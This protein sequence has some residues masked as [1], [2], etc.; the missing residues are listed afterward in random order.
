[1]K[2]LEKKTKQQKP[3]LYN[4]SQE[5]L[6]KLSKN[7]KSSRIKF[8]A[9]IGGVLVF[10]RPDFVA[11]LEEGVKQCVIDNLGLFC[12]KMIEQPM[13]NSLALLALLGS[14]VTISSYKIRINAL[15]KA[16]QEIKD[17]DLSV[18]SKKQKTLLNVKCKLTYLA[19]VT[20]GLIGLLAV[21]TDVNLNLA[22]Y[23]IIQ[24]IADNLLHA[25]EGAINEPLIAAAFAGTTFLIHRK[26][27]KLNTQKV[28]NTMKERAV[29][30]MNDMAQEDNIIETDN[31]EGE[32]VYV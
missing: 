15:K 27:N 13:V 24:P 8:A 17:G 20:T 11:G 2:L 4:I 26:L 19:E 9:L 18:L 29:R 16:S 6:E 25:V 1:M 12:S 10:N 32:A 31:K 23:S 22:N 21:S 14:C 28:K 3:P 30:E 7:L 5:R